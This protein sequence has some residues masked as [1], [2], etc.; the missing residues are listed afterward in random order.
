M[1]ATVPHATCG[2]G[3]RKF[4][5]DGFLLPR[6]YSKICCYFNDNTNLIH[7]Y[8]KIGILYRAALCITNIFVLTGNTL[9]LFNRNSITSGSCILR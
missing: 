3:L 8:V 1:M 6:V 7:I 5:A 9:V 4:K 2:L